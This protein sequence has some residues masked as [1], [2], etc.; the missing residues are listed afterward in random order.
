MDWRTTWQDSDSRS[1]GLRGQREGEKKNKSNKCCVLDRRA[2][3]SPQHLQSKK[4]EDLS[5]EPK[6]VKNS[7]VMV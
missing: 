1:S 7:S 2:F 6:D 5:F 4:Q 3:G